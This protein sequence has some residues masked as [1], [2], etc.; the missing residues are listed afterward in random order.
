VSA[1]YSDIDNLAVADLLVTYTC[2]LVPDQAQTAALRAFLERGGR[3]IALH[4]TNAILDFLEDGRIDVAAGHD[5]FMDLIGSRFLAH[6]P[7][8]PFQV[9]ITEPGHPLTMGIEPFE[10]IDEL[11]LF[12]ERAEFQTLL[13]TRFTGSCSPFAHADWDTDK[14]PVMYLRPLGR[15]SVLY[16]S[17]GHCRSHFD[18]SP[19]GAFFIHPLRCAWNYP[20]YYEL[21]RRALHWGLEFQ[22]G[23]AARS[24]R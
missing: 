15:G 14:A 16:C 2:D 8:G 23:E 24:L 18:P 10:V 7:I 3:W 4:G 13:S 11:Y 5:D 1:N 20:V 17:L 19:S 21:L 22:T 9:E 12:E 6:P